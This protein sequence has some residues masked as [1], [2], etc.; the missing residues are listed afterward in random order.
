MPVGKPEVIHHAEYEHEAKY[1]SQILDQELDDMEFNGTQPSFAGR[2]Q[3]TTPLPPVG[4]VVFDPTLDGLMLVHDNVC[5][6]HLQWV[7]V[8]G[9]SACAT[10]Q[11]L[12]TLCLAHKWLPEGLRQPHQQRPLNLIQRTL[13]P[14]VRLTQSL[15]YFFIIQKSEYHIWN[16][17]ASPGPASL[18]FVLIYN[19][20]PKIFGHYSVHRNQIVNWN[21]PVISVIV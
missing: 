20:C 6:G 15:E 3:R 13:L 9:E 16:F 21:H 2:L 10:K 17:I 1:R 14:A 11:M 19:C 7:C 5:S 12:R 4:H 8:C 18:L